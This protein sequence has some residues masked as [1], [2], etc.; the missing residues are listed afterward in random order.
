[1]NYFDHVECVGLS[2]IER[3]IKISLVCKSLSAS[4]CSTHIFQSQGDK[5]HKD[6]WQ[7]EL[8]FTWI[9]IFRFWIDMVRLKKS[10]FVLLLPNFIYVKTEQIV[11]FITARPNKLVR[12]LWLINVALKCINW[13]FTSFKNLFVLVP[14]F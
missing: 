1:M 11:V 8:W 14:T 9:F 5:F 12:V 3:H 4:H 6:S 2:R 10:L 13:M 7:L